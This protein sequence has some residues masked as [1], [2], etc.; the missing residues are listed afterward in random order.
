[1]ALHPFVF[2]DGVKPFGKFQDVDILPDLFEVDP[3]FPTM[4]DSH[5]HPSMRVTEIEMQVV[6]GTRLAEQGRLAGGTDL[7]SERRRLD[8]QIAGKHGPQP[9][10]R[11][12][13]V[14]LIFRTD[15]PGSASPFVFAQPGAARG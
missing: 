6:T 8:C 3:D 12:C 14:H 15:E 13:E 4:R 11:Q 2:G 10:M 7:K 5:K 1:M 9:T